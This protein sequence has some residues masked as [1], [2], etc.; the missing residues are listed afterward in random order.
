[1]GRFK[2]KKVV[3]KKIEWNEKG[4]LIINGRSA[5]KFRIEKKANVDESVKLKKILNKLKIPSSLLNNKQ[6]LVNYLTANPM[7]LTQLLAVIGE[8]TIG[9]GYPDKEDMKKIK[10]RVNKARSKS[11]SSKE[12]QYHEIDW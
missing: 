9:G 8:D 2:N 3:I 5:M 4:D 10:K 7:I 1:M 6:K 12:Y 11:D